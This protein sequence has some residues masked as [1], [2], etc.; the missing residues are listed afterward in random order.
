MECLGEISGTSRDVSSG[1]LNGISGGSRA[2]LRGMWR[3]SKD[4]WGH[5]GICQVYLLGISLLSRQYLT[6][7]SFISQGNPGV[8]QEYVGL[9]RDISGKSSFLSRE[10]SGTAWDVSGTFRGYLRKSW[11][12]SRDLWLFRGYF[13]YMSE[14]FGDV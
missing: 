13:Q 5:F 9:S 7:V 3:L 12:I 4:I 14:Y 10:F 8:S 1:D 6:R 11:T 2:C